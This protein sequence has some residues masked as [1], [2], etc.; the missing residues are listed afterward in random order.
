[1]MT[2]R[3]GTDRIKELKRKI[4]QE[5]YLQTAILEIASLLTES[6]NKSHFLLHERKQ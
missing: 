6:I 3:K 4:Q 5:E 2:D 1:M